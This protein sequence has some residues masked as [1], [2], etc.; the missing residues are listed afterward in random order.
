MRGKSIMLAILAIVV[1]R[2]GWE[3]EN[4]LAPN[5]FYRRVRIPSIVEK[6][7]RKKRD[8]RSKRL[9]WQLVFKIFLV[10]PEPKSIFF[11]KKQNILI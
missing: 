9:F 4:A 10:F 3:G 8:K 5:T 11:L 1:L 2:C 7:W 6:G